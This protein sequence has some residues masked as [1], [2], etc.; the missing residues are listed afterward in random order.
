M[1]RPINRA[2]RVTNTGFT[3]VELLVVIAIIGVLIALLL[4]AVQAARE[5]ARR[6]TCQNQIKQ[7]GLAAHVHFDTHKHFPTNGWGWAWVGDPDQGFGREQPGGWI[8][9]TLPYIEQQALHDR[10][11]GAATNVKRV[12]IRN[13]VETPV[14]IFNCPTRRQAKPYRKEWDGPFVARNAQ[15]SEPGRLIAARTDYAICIGV[16]NG[17]PHGGGP[18]TYEQ[19]LSPSY[20]PAFGYNPSTGMVGLGYEMSTV[21]LGDIIDGASNTLYVGE[22]YLNP[23][24]YDTGGDP[25]DNES[26]YTGHNNDTSRTAGPI[27]RTANDTTAA[28]FQPRQDTPGFGSDSL[29][30]SAHSA[31]FNVCL[32]DGSVRPLSYDVDK[33]VFSL[34]GSREDERSFTMPE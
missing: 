17:I 32:C 23:D 28:A 10:G 34:M 19:A 2:K 16:T 3:L 12:E 27:P 26:A 7:M 30:G 8:Y 20:V 29:F 22:K 1:R 11:K 24:H 9:N 6:L 21:T 5:A 13:V 31:T 18:N 4:P 33:L 25:A 14:A 15:N